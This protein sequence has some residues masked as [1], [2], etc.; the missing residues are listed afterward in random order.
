MRD[1]TPLKQ[2]DL[3]EIVMEGVEQNLQ[4][5]DNPRHLGRISAMGQ[6]FQ[7]MQQ[8]D[9]QRTRLEDSGVSVTALHEAVLIL[10]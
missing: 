6:D 7:N 4:N 2:S 5:F 10:Q 3:H 9:Q 8:V 1:D